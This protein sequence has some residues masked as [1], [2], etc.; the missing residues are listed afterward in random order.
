MTSERLWTLLYG[1][2]LYLS[3]LNIILLNVKT[4]NKRDSSGYFRKSGKLPLLCNN[5]EKSLQK[6]LGAAW[7]SVKSNK[8]RESC[9]E[10]I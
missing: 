1:H 2:Q 9:Q 7:A 8:D 5:G 10:P 4:Q 6:A 3:S